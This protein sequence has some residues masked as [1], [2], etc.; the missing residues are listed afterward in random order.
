MEQRNTDDGAAREA[1]VL[2]IDEVNEVCMPSEW[3]DLT[4]ELGDQPPEYTGFSIRDDDVAD[5]AVGKIAEARREYTR[6]KELADREIARICAKVEQ[7]RLRMETDTSYLTNRLEDYA[8]GV[9]PSKVTKTG[10]TYKLI[11]GTLRRKFGGVEYHRDDEAL[12]R[13]LQETG[14]ADLIKLK[15]SPDWAGLKKQTEVNE[16]GIV[17]I[18]ETGEVVEGVTTERRPDTFEVEIATATAPGVGSM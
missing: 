6:I 7:A 13:W 10:S 18:P 3:Q 2:R 17:V 1:L 16:D 4:E 11:N 8:A 9:T 12:L 14:R 5:W 15:A